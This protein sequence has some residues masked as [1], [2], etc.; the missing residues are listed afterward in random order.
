MPG[1]WYR[2]AQT[3]GVALSANNHTRG[4]M[5]LDQQDRLPVLQL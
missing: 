1:A 3:K 5:Q 2:Y 4:L